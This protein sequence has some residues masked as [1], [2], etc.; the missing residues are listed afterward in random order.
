VFGDL[1]SISTATPTEVQ[2]ATMFQ[3]SIMVRDLTDALDEAVIVTVSKENFKSGNSG[4]VMREV[5]AE[6]QAK[7]VEY[8]EAREAAVEAAMDDAPDE[9]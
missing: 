7:V 6:V 3:G 8:A 5:D 9:L 4:W 1:N 2:S